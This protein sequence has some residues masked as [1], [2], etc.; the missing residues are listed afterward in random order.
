MDASFERE[1]TP[2]SEERRAFQLGSLRSTFN[3]T[4][5]VVSSLLR[6]QSSY[7]VQL[8]NP[9]TMHATDQSNVSINVAPA[10]E[11]KPAVDPAAVDSNTPV[12]EKRVAQFGIFTALLNSGMILACSNYD[13]KP[14]KGTGNSCTLESHSRDDCSV[15]KPPVEPPPAPEL[16]AEEKAEEKKKEA[17]LVRS[18][19]RGKTIE[20]ETAPVVRTFIERSLSFRRHSIIHRYPS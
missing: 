5:F 13:T 14:P 11:T 16:S 18:K 6:N 8:V 3:V 4:T 19:K 7:N 1:S 17:A 12:P 15:E 20:V 9:Q 10:D 2:S